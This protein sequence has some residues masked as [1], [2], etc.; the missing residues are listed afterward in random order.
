MVNEAAQVLELV[1]FNSGSL[2]ISF[3]RI[4]TSSLLVVELMRS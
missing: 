2:G 4:Q 1:L 3:V